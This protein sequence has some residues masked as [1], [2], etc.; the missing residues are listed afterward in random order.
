MSSKHFVRTVNH[1]LNDWLCIKSVWLLISMVIY[2]QVTLFFALNC[3]FFSGHW[4]S[5]TKT[6]Q[7]I[8]CQGFFQANQ[9]HCRKINEKNKNCLAY[10]GSDQSLVIL[11]FRVLNCASL[12]QIKIT[13]NWTEWRAILVRNYTCDSKSKLTLHTCSILKLCVWF[14]TKLHSLQF[15]YHC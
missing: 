10:F 9:S 14:Q 11:V 1:F 3:I 7:L 6:K 2:S 13:W 8:R 12:K 5:N 15:N 4:E